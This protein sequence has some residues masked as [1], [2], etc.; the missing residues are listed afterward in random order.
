M[1]KTIA[2]IDDDEAVRESTRQ[3]LRSLGY[4]TAAFSSA[5]EFLQSGDVVGTSCVISDVQM[6]G[7]GGI[8]LQARLKDQETHIPVIFITAFP[9]ERV[10]EQVLAAGACG[11]L[12]KPYQ[13]NCLVHCIE[14]ALKS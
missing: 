1:P 11:F 13:E 4:T 14:T 3:L 5:E 8:G 10:K 12:V 2:I 7:M 9:E 6:P